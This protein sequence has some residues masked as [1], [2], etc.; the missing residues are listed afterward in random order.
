MVIAFF[1]LFSLL[2][3]HR[4]GHN[5]RIHLFLAPAHGEQSILFFIQTHLKTPYENIQYFSVKCFKLIALIFICFS[6]FSSLWTSARHHTCMVVF[7][8]RHLLYHFQLA[9]ASAKQYNYTILQCLFF[10][11]FIIFFQRNCLVCAMVRLSY[12]MACVQF[13]QFDVIWPHTCPEVASV[14]R[15]G[16]LTD[17]VCGLPAVWCHNMSVCLGAKC[18]FQTVH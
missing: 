2:A 5:E 18:P 9:V 4:R 6:L 13:T 7:L 8:H 11:S 10:I 12:L 1:P 17:T 16:W 15:I 3:H 14:K